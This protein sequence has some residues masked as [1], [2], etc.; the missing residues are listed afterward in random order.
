MRHILD[1][2]HISMRVRHIEQALAGIYALR[3]AHQAGLGLI[4]VDVQ[5]L[6][7]LIWNGY[8]EEAAQ[9]LWAVRH[10]AGEAVY[11]NGSHVESPMR[12]FLLH[13]QELCAYLI[14]NNGAL[15]DY[16]VRYRA[17]NAISSS[18]AG[19]SVDEIANARMA[20]RRRMR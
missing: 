17:G 11:L 1:W 7:N 5:R 20:K 13:C 12:R 19:A 14:N 16:G 15:I 2:W 9:T 8:A 10:L 18:R 3:P 4:R 6:R